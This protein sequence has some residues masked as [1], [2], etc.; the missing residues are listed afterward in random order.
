MVVN[1]KKERFAFAGDF[2]RL[3]LAKII[4]SA[5][6]NLCNLIKN[7]WTFLVIRWYKICTNGTG[8]WPFISEY[9]VNF[10]V[11]SLHKP[12]YLGF[13]KFIL[14]WLKVVNL[15][16]KVAIRTALFFTPPQN[17]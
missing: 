13:R 3:I 5:E 8:R 4:I 17:A 6:V 11:T 10:C 15:T 9:A 2:H 7:F 14:K 1:G 12:L 16:L